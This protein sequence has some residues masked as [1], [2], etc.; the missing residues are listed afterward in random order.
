MIRSD[1]DRFVVFQMSTEKATTSEPDTKRSERL[2][3]LKELHFRRV[4]IG[5]SLELETDRS[6]CF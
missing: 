2:A 4:R 3:R 6:P 5:R 1:R